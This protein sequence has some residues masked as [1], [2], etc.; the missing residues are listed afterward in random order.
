[1]TV[2]CSRCN[3]PRWPSE[4]ITEPYVCQRC[5]E[6]LAGGNAVDPCPTEAQRAAWSA[7]GERLRAFRVVSH[8]PVREVLTLA[9][10]PKSERAREGASVADCRCRRACCSICGP[11]RL[12]QVVE[13]EKPTSPG[14]RALRQQV[15]LRDGRRCRRCETRHQLTAHHIRPREDGGSDDLSNLITLCENCHDWAEIETASL[16]RAMNVAELTCPPEAV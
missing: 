5:R 13:L 11:E 10:K 3:E 14:W 15:I 4:A 2:T 12:G 8:S 6:V 1:M 16:G 9:E 7:A